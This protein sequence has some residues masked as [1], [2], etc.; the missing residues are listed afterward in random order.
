MASNTLEQ[1]PLLGNNTN[2]TQIDE[3][4]ANARIP[5]RKCLNIPRGVLA[6]LIFITIMLLSF[7]FLPHNHT[8]DTHEDIVSPKQ[9]TKNI[10]EHLNKFYLIAQNYD[11][12][13]SSIKKASS[14]AELTTFDHDDEENFAIDSDNPRPSRSITTGYNASAQYITSLLTNK[15]RCEI[16]LQYF[17]VP[18]WE[19][20]RE[21][22]LN[23]TFL[24]DDDAKQTVIYQGGVDFWS[25]RYGGQAANLTNQ[26]IVVT[27]NGCDGKG[28]GDVEDKIVLIQEDGKCEFWNLAYKA[29]LEGASAV[30]FYNSASRKKLLFNRVRIV[31]W[32]EGDPIMTI[33]VLAASFSLGQLLA[34]SKD[35]RIDLQTYTKISI[36][37]T[38]NVICSLKDGGH[39]ENTLVFG[40]HLDSVPA[41][42]GLVDNAS[43]SSTLL[44]ILLV[45]EKTNFK[46]E[47][48]LVFAWWGAEEIGL[49]GSRYFVQEAVMSGESENIAM[50]LNFDMLGSP[51]FVPFIHR[52]ED[53]PEDVRNASIVIQTTFQSFFK[54]IR[55]PYELTDMVA[56]SDFLPFIEHGIP[57][58]GI[59]T[60][61]GEIKSE[62]QRH[63]FRGFANAPFDP[64]YHRS[65]DTIE[66]VSEDAI[67]LMSQAALYAIKTFAKEKHIRC[68]LGRTNS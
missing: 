18:I 62:E 1:T 63:T 23:V 51:N 48:H 27:P 68:F 16:Q 31:D 60:G 54:A 37:D 12:N 13:D 44:E 24:D 58:G 25:M 46:P 30:I 64:C 53:A 59:L 57:S 10:F 33:P 6:L 49:L 21:A 19:K 65:C 2:A 39:K 67:S 15:T 9:I 11:R 26:K 28:W 56:G 36:V 52:G 3:E 41:G 14:V 45:L 5:N 7:I 34:F 38:Y 4:N 47:N 22:E 50:N 61:A 20:F 35:K 43:G 40:A 29:E 17:K 66:N 55:E 8:E 42:P 32:K